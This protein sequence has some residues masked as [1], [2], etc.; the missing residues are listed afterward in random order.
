LL[1]SLLLSFPSAS[2]RVMLSIVATNFS[3]NHA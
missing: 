2:A 3:C 1:S